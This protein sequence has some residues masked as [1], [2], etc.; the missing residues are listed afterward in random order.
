MQAIEEAGLPIKS[1]VTVN[2]D[3][4]TLEGKL[5]G[6]RFI[7]DR[8]FFALFSDVNVRSI[9][10]SGYEG[11]DIVHDLNTPIPD[12]LAGKFD[13]VFDGSCFDNMFNPAC[14]IMNAGRLLRAGGRVMMGEH[15]S[16]YPY[17]Y[18]M[19][20]PEWFNDYFVANRFAYCRPG[21]AI[22]D[23]GGIYMDMYLWDPVHQDKTG[24]WRYGHSHIQTKRNVSIGVMAEKG[25]HST[26]DR[27][28]IQAIYRSE[29]DNE[30]YIEWSLSMR[31]P[32]RLPPPY[33]DVNPNI[34][35]KVLH[36]TYVGSLRTDRA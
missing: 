5:H 21:I 25:E 28:P 11:A 8:S 24:K 9:D 33:K 34:E 14:G 10:V 16:L 1:G 4:S 15:G 29:E 6:S 2:Y 36:G 20:S 12:H 23:D 26:W 27:M 18:L 3:T 31:D 17:A 30:R 7:D 13:F 19:Y 32:N 35:D 22:W